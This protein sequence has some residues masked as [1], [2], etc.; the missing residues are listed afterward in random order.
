MTG[1]TQVE[2]QNLI[3]RGL[4]ILPKPALKEVPVRPKHAE[5]MREYRIKNRE[6]LIKQQRER[7]HRNK[8]QL[9]AHS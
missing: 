8:E 3:S 2:V 7:Y 6:R 9:H 1:L 4:I 5:Y